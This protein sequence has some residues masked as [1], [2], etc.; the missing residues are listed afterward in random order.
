MLTDRLRNDVPSA[1]WFVLQ[2]KD[3]ALGHPTAEARLKVND[4]DVLRLILG[5]A[6]S[7]D[8]ELEACYELEERD[9]E[10]IAVEFG[11]R[12]ETGLRP[13]SLVPWRSTRDAPYLNHGGFE[14]PLMPEGRKP[15]A[16]FSEPEPSEWLDELLILFEPF[17]AEG[18][19]IR[20]VVRQAKTG[21][22]GSAMC[23][24]REVYFSL[25]D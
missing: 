13:V 6:A 20:R 9:L 22:D 18:R 19:I 2:A 25:A 21:A 11:V 8:A 14:L 5:D 7:D 4:L 16:K 12:F 24:M 3:A 17:V 10:A 23:M 1:R 15:F